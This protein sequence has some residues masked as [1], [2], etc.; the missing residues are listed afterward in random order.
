M[1]ARPSTGQSEAFATPEAILDPDLPIV[2][3]HHHLWFFPETA[4]ATM[5]KLDSLVARLSV[6]TYRRNARYLLD[7]YMTDVQTGHNVRASVFVDARAM[8]RTT[9]SDEMKSVGEIE[10]VNGVAA[11]AASGLFGDVK[12]GAGIVGGADLRMGDAIESVLMAHI[13]VGGGRYRGVRAAWTIHD[14]DERILGAGRPAGVLLD[15]KFREGFQW[16]QRLG[17]SFDALILE[18]QLPE[19]VDLARA[20][21]YT[22]IVLNHVG[23]PVGVGRYAGKRQERFVTWRDNMR[24]LADCDNVTVKLGGLGVGLAAFDSARSTS[25]PTSAQLASE[26]RPYIETCIEQFGAHRCMFESNFP[27]DSAACSYPVLWNAFKRIAAGCSNEEKT[28]LFSD[29]AA[30]VYRLQF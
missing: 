16:L 26:W 29:T 8:Y 6:P 25:P 11:M 5:E 15:A 19:L 2:D 23:M 18:P 22:S 17:L 1:L 27:V 13:Q 14:A 24:A 3:A 30:R 21:P 20:F 7:E 10:F 4:I 12:V 28:A 9:G